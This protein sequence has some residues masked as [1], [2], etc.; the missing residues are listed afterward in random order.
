MADPKYNSRIE[1]MGGA[2]D[3]VNQQ[4]TTP[5]R[6][7]A[8]RLRVFWNGQLAQPADG[9]WGWTELTDQSI[10]FDAQTPRVGDV[11]EAHYLEKDV[12]GQI[13]VEGVIGSPHAPGEC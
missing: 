10:Q 7:Q 3:G 11:I 9:R 8:G 6:Y 12:A 5:T 13:G 1:I 2:V 4:F